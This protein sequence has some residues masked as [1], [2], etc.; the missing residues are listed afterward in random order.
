MLGVLQFITCYVNKYQVGLCSFT[1]KDLGHGNIFLWK[2]HIPFLPLIYH[3][4]MHGYP[5]EAFVNDLKPLPHVGFHFQDSKHLLS[6]PLDP[7][8]R[9]LCHE[10][11]PENYSGCLVTLMEKLF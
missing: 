3:S 9:D 7:F 5:S 4:F 1:I 8:P 10:S 11:E 6:E 2:L